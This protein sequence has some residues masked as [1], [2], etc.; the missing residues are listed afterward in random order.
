M[1]FLAGRAAR[2]LV[3]A[4]AHVDQP[5]YRA[6]FALI[7]VI[8]NTKIIEA[9]VAYDPAVVVDLDPRRGD[10]DCGYWRADRAFVGYDRVGSNAR[11]DNMILERNCGAGTRTRA[12]D[13]RA[14]ISQHNVAGVDDDAA[15]GTAGDDAAV[16]NRA[17]PA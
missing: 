5:H 13:D 15:F 16:E 4:G 9:Y 6:A 12:G 17:V 11:A 2:H 7:N 8:E 1:D 14:D 10:F 3:V